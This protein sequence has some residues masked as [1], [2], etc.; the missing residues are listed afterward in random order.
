MNRFLA[1]IVA[2]LTLAAS[3]KAQ[4]QIGTYNQPVVNPRPVIS[5]YLNLNHGG[6]PPAINYYG[7][8]RPQIENHQAIQNLQQQVQTTQG[9]IQNQAAPL[10]NDEMAP[11]GRNVGGYL[12]YSHC[13]PLYSR[14]AGGAAGGARR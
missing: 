14:G 8:V 4:P 12:N 1:G 7:I 2:T 13:F 10:A 6:A 5:P 9:M 11:T 3:L